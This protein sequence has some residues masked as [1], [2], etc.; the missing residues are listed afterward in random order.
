MV[1]KCF[2]K[3]KGLVGKEFR[4]LEVKGNVLDGTSGIAVGFDFRNDDDSR[5]RDPSHTQAAPHTCPRNQLKVI[6]I[7]VSLVSGLPLR[8]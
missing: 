8:I 2:G 6:A 5:L 1:W 3:K 7:W 4:A